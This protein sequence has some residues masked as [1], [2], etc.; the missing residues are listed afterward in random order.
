VD[1]ADDVR[2]RAGGHPALTLVAT[3]LG[4]FMIFLDATIVNVALP[5]IGED[6]HVGESGLQW[7]VAAY[8]LT[9]GMFMMS[10]ASLADAKGRRRTYVVGLVI[11]CVASLACGLAPGNTVLSIT[12][13]L[14]GVGAAVVN[15][16]SLALV[17]AAYPDPA[18]KAKAVGL[19]TGIAG[20]GI[21][22]GP[23]LGGVLTETVGWR[24][25]FL[26]N[27]FI[28]AVAIALTYA[29]VRESR[30]ER[31]HSF[32]P[33]GQ[34]LFLTAIG[35]L[36]YSLVQAPLEGFGSPLI[37]G[38]LIGGVVALVTFVWF[39]LRSP[40]PMMDVRVFADLPYSAA[41]VTVFAVLFSAYGT[42]LVVTQY[43]QNIKDFSPERTGLLLLAFALPTMVLAPIAGR[44]AGRIGG[45]RPTLIG[46]ALALASGLVL[47]AS[48][49][50]PLWLTIVGLLCIGAGAGL[51]IAPATAVA[52]SSIDP[53][54]SG[55]AS[56]ILSAQR[57]LGSTAG[58]AVM[59][60]ILALVVS[61]QLPSALEPVIPDPTERAAVV[62][63]IVASANPQ[64]VPSVIAPAPAGGSAISRPE[65]VA[66]ADDVFAQGIR[67]AELV[68]VV[69]TAVAFVFGW[70]CFPRSV[71][72]EHA[73]E[74][75]E[76]VELDVAD[77]DAG[78]RRPGTPR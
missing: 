54:R 14:Q 68:G 26:V 6:F 27:P 18:A 7:V 39:E 48:M 47:A 49:G 53:E 13:G 9:M 76:A 34:V 51:S 45:R 15:V 61:V 12:R 59:G 30:A 46:I 17:G 57:A 3:G 8:S 66:V 60:S 35:L 23:T 63:D 74:Q 65:V 44:I 21:A 5:A 37:F 28:G 70:R 58:F 72:S 25:V 71:R 62:D 64:A 4:L 77:G 55:M 75:L 73:E 1:A 78:V 29:A 52:M 33:V 2:A 41:I 31:A 67:L 11:F 69:L 40:D 24:W 43:F 38:P 16:A 19:W 36:T 32:D 56:G 42:L 50:G 20:I 10:S 22:V